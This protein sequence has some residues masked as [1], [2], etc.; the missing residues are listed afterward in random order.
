MERLPFWTPADGGSS[1][2]SFITNLT[3]TKLI[4]TQVEGVQLA[5]GWRVTGFLIPGGP[6]SSGHRQ[7]FGLIYP[8]F[9]VTVVMYLCMFLRTAVF[10]PSY[11]TVELLCPFS[12][13]QRVFSLWCWSDTW[14]HSA[15][16][17][18]SHHVNLSRI[19]IWFE[20]RERLLRCQHLLIMKL[21]KAKENS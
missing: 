6:S 21:L 5:S 18:K 15:Q 12:E 3:N 20:S 13:F 10:S 7:S 16:A 17:H 11:R 19:R 2:R 4:L 9:G 1:Q 14:F 8:F